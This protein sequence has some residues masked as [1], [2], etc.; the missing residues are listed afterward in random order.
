MSKNVKCSLF[1]V[2]LVVIILGIIGCSTAG[3]VR[4]QDVES[5]QT[6]SVVESPDPTPTPSPTPTPIIDR[7]EGSYDI[8]MTPLFCTGIPTPEPED[9]IA[10]SDEA[11]EEG[12][13]D[14]DEVEGDEDKAEADSEA[15]GEDGEESEE[16][17]GPVI[18]ASA[19]SDS[20]AYSYETIDTHTLGLTV[21]NEVDMEKYATYRITLKSGLKFKDGSDVT[22]DDV[23]FS[24]KQLADGNYHGDYSLS[25]LDI[26]GMK[27]YNTQ[28]PR[29]D[30]EMV[31]RIIDA[32]INEDGTYPELEGIDRELQ[33]EVWSGLDEAGE[34]FAEQIIEYV[35]SYYALNAYVNAF[36]S[37]YLTYAK[38]QADENLRVAFAYIMWGY[39]KG[40]NPYNYRKNTLTT[41]SGKV[42]E[43]DVV[44]LGAI[45]LWQEIHEYEGDN[46]TEDGIDYDK[47]ITGK[48]IKDFIAEVYYEKQGYVIEDIEGIF[49][50]TVLT[51]DRMNRR[52]CLYVVIGKDEDITRFNFY[53]TNPR[54]YAV[55][56]VLNEP[57]FIEEFWDEDTEG[58][59]SE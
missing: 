29:K 18:F 26:L 12:E 28:V 45:D 10:D 38:V 54:E 5:E 22:A 23:I 55:T 6:G 50:G 59:D 49:K 17:L 13:S 41:V 37:G 1:I 25:D 46:F 14:T 42:H 4:K 3:S 19:D 39:G 40:K 34:R 21:F 30:R 27:E 35:N 33:E 47:T 36:M 24:I 7:E 9:I 43:L 15:E 8:D 51:E 48:S 52:E 53:L 58:E 57:E 16:D 31:E 32:G 11:G 56:G 20:I 44:S 2:I